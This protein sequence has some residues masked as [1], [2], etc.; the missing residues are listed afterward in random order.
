MFS[1]ASYSLLLALRRV[2]SLTWIFI[3]LATSL[4]TYWHVFFLY[5][6]LTSLIIFESSEGSLQDPY[7]GIIFFGLP[8]SFL[9]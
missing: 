3:S 4:F 8:I 9:F 5:F 6:L 2:E 1:T 7:L